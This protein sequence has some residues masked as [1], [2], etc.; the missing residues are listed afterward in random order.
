M[1]TIQKN[2]VKGVR[3]ATLEN[4][5]GKTFLKKGNISLSP[6]ATAESHADNKTKRLGG[7]WKSIQEEEK[8]EWGLAYSRNSVPVA[9]VTEGEWYKIKS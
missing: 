2:T 1:D 5:Q 9:P 7:R 3:V 6:N 4:N 8:I